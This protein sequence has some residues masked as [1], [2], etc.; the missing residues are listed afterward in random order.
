MML[1]YKMQQI[2]L[3]NATALL[4]Q[5]ATVITKCVNF[6][7]KCDRFYKM[8][9][10]YY[11][12]RQSLQIT[13]ITKYFD[14][15]NNGHTIV[16]SFVV[17]IS[18][19]MFFSFSTKELLHDN[20]VKLTQIVFTSLLTFLGHMYITFQSCSEAQPRLLQTSKTESCVAKLLILDICRDPG[21]SY[22]VT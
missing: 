17:L 9:Q 15:F 6:I 12:M 10:F 3:E 4:L 21:Y 13:F 5:N 2:L 7:A 1:Y 22:V 19:T 16:F 18:M 8:R 20:F 14:T 11:K